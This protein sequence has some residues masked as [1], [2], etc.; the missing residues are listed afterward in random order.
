[1]SFSTQPHPPTLPNRSRHDEVQIEDGI[2]SSNQK[3][4]SY[5]IIMD[6]ERKQIHLN[7]P[8]NDT[9]LMDERGLQVG[10]WSRLTS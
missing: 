6:W 4:R 5:H 10:R 9:K 1:M 8:E 3:Q 7:D 2:G